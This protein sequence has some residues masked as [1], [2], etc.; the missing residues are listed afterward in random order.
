MRDADHGAYGVEGREEL[1]CAYHFGG[2]GVR[3]EGGAV[4]SLRTYEYLERECVS[5]CVCV[6]VRGWASIKAR[7]PVSCFCHLV[8]FV[9]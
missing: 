1:I 5:E 7:D 8:D 2:M 4:G 3:A 6:C 9:M